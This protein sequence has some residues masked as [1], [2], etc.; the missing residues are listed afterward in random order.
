[1]ISRIFALIQF[2][3][4]GDETIVKAAPIVAWVVGGG[5]TTDQIE[6][7]WYPQKDYE[8][9]LAD[10]E[11]IPSNYTVELYD[12]ILS[13]ECETDFE[14]RGIPPWFCLTP[15]NL[16]PHI[17]A[18]IFVMESKFDRYALLNKNGLEIDN[19]PPD[20]LGYVEYFGESADRSILSQMIDDS[21]N[22]NNSKNGLFYASCTNHG[23][24]FNIGPSRANSIIIDG[25]TTKDLVGD[26]FW[27]RNKF[28]HFVYDTCRRGPTQ[29]NL[30]CNHS[31]ACMH[32]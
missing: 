22:T 25:Y 28:P 26:W 16:Y 15:H 6:T 8:T 31:P 23:G 2:G 19:L 10:K 3:R 12:M 4:H 18:P 21:A 17:E 13:S 20:F 29:R 9:W 11:Q 30:P 27:E 1:M 7:P 14:E 5:N 32:N 24:G